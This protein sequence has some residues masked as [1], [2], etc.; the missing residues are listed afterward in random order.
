MNTTNQFI[1]T[2]LIFI[3]LIIAFTLLQAL[4]LGHIHIMGV[5]TPLLYTYL[6]LLFPKTYPK[7]AQ[8]LLCFA[9]GL[10]VDMFANTPG[11]AAASMT[12]IGFIQ[13]YILNLYLSEENNPDLMP[14]FNTLGTVKFTTYAFI[15]V[16]IY[17]IVFFSLEAFSS[18]RWTDWLLSMAGS[19]VL[20][21]TFIFTIDSVRR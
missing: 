18:I 12:L 21:L 8:L 17:C 2:P 1:S 3:I 11:L 5:A 6:A 7:W 9:M 20:T 13:P 15:L 19:L 4:L 10:S 16:T 14:G